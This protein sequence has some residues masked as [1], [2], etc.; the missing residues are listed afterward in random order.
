[1]NQ[2]QISLKLREFTNTQLEKEL[3][4]RKRK[5]K[6]KVLGYRAIISGDECNYGSYQDSVISQKYPS[7]TTKEKCKAFAERQIKES[8]NG[9]YIVTLFKDTPIPTRIN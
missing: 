1:M 2:K 7:R 4:I 9:G 3:E 5:S 6:G 8:K